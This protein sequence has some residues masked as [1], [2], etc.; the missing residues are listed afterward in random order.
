MRKLL[1]LATFLLL[2]AVLWAAPSVQVVQCESFEKKGGW[3][4]DSQFLMEMGSPYLLAHGLGE[5]VADASTTVTLPAHEGEW[6][7]YVRTK[8]WTRYWVD[9]S[10][11][12]VRRFQVSVDGQVLGDF[13]QKASAEWSWEKA[14]ALK[15]A[16]GKHTLT[17]HDLDGFD[18]R[19]DAIA[20]APAGVMP[21]EQIGYTT[22]TGAPETMP[23]YDLVVCGGGIAGICSAISAARLGLKVAL[24]EARPI[25]GGANSSEV[26]VH[27]GGYIHL[28][29]YK[30]LGDVVAEI[31]PKNGGNAQPAKNYEDNRK[32]EVVAAEKNIT[33]YLHTTVV[34]VERNTKTREITAVRGW[35]TDKG[36]LLRFEAPLFVDC[37]GD[38]T[39]GYLAD[40][41]YRMGRESRAETG[42]SMAP[43]VA[44]KMTMGASVQWY[45]T[46]RK[47]PTAFPSE[48]WM[49]PFNETNCEYGMRGDWDWETGMMRNQV[50]EFERIRDYGLLVVYSNWSYLKNKSAKREKYEK[51]GLDWA[52]FVAGKRESRRLIGDHIMTQQDIV[53]NVAYPDGTCTTSWTIDLHYPMP[54]FACNYPGEP[55]RSISTHK[56]H[57]GYQIPYRCLYSQSINNLFMA[58]RNISVTHVALGTV[59]VMRT[60]GM[61]GEVVGMAASLCRKYECSPRDIYLV[62]LDELKDLMK[63]G[64]G[65]GVPQPAQTYNC[66]QMSLT[67]KTPPTDPTTVLA[68]A[69]QG[70][71]RIVCVGDSITAGTDKGFS[72][73]KALARMLDERGYK[74]EFGGTQT[75]TRTP[76]LMHEGFPGAPAEK[77]A[78]NFRRDVAQANADILIIHAGHNHTAAEKPVAGIIKANHRIIDI[79]RS[80]NPRVM[81][82]V[83]SVIPSGKLPKYSYIP[84]LGP[85]LKTMV[86]E[87]NTVE[88]P[89]RFV[90]LSHIF[91]WQTDAIEDKVHPNEN[92]SEK[93]AQAIVTNLLPYLK[94]FKQN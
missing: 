93:I 16:A 52:A 87:V 56:I 62:H 33:V 40:A 1:S 12:A 76:G 9:D 86:D 60:T 50:R 67:M 85:A 73:V 69:P 81:I 35:D 78:E 7:V 38:G 39:V 90:D 53:N 23:K 28:P 20:F 61:M 27:L 17:L 13:P 82:L 92:G 64:I 37:T 84:E 59:R 2:G 31:G 5:P 41:P 29:P 74:A 51:A 45:S 88:S 44:D 19:C 25:L 65:T 91:K 70:L 15:L 58:G 54:R 55:F 10:L 18:G 63:K 21:P 24:I 34:G 30:K 11:P 57:G 14:G 26:R 47:A 22:F 43:L 71:P 3:V 72:Y 83:A 6:V 32:A 42:E 66:G 89:V 46:N 77:V 80:I 75:S 8:D 36:R 48:P 49:I 68:E 94:A 4:V 79:A